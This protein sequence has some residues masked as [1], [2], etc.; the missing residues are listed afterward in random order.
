VTPGSDPYARR[1]FL[2][3]LPPYWLIL[4]LLALYPGLTGVLTDDWWVFY[5]LL[6][7]FPV[8]DTTACLTAETAGCGIPTAVTLPGEVWFYVLLPF[9]VLLI[10]ALA[11]GLRAPRWLRTELLLLG[12][13]AAASV[14]ARVWSGVQGVPWVFYS[15]FGTFLWL[16][17]G[18]AIAAVSV[19]R[20]GK[21]PTRAQELISRHPTPL[22]AAA[23]GICAALGLVYPIPVQEQPEALAIAVDMI[24]L[25]AAGVLF[26]LPAVVGESGGG[27]PRRVLSIRLLGW[28]GVISY[29]LYLFHIPI[30]RE[31]LRVGAP[32]LLPGFSLI[33][34]LVMSVVVSVACA[35]ASYYLFE[36]PI[37][38]FKEPRRR[39][40]SLPAAP[41][42]LQLSV[43]LLGVRDRREDVLP[44]R[45]GPDRRQ[46]LQHGLDPLGEPRVGIGSEHRH[47]PHPLPAHDPSCERFHPGVESAGREGTLAVLDVVPRHALQQLEAGI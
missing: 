5:G 19:A 26:M 42:N 18:M 24:A 1:R 21:P 38:R 35:A 13:L 28:L 11:K 36:K 37:L 12:A 31:L 46:A 45:E 44:A 7:L 20:E 4:T 39:A 41:S 29:G 16:A 6:Q 25:G 8:Y 40:R 47:E 9:Y 2:R 30:E 43:Q 27:L 32:G 17:L 23:I 10:A 15:T 3:I 22:W 33:A 34:L 14:L